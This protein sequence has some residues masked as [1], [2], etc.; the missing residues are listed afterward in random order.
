M[1][2]EETKRT[3]G[4]A[5]QSKRN[6]HLQRDPDLG[7]EHFVLGQLPW[8]RLFW[9]SLAVLAGAGLVWALTQRVEASSVHLF[10]LL[11]VSALVLLIAN[12]T[13]TR[14]IKFASDAQ[15]LYF[16]SRP[17]SWARAPAKS[18]TWLF[19]PWSNV[20]AIGVQLMLDES[21]SRK[22]VTFRIRVSHDEQRDYLSRVLM[23]NLDRHESDTDDGTILVGFS[24]GL[25]SPHRIVVLMGQ[26]QRGEKK[27]A[28][29]PD[30][31]L[32]ARAEGLPD[33]NNLPLVSGL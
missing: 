5:D 7:V 29:P 3:T 27:K 2:S 28:V 15:G 10:G 25:T 24:T 19:V 18:Q 9:Q 33:M 17:K 30:D 16:P 23:P 13:P 21:G 31:G 32:Q 22:G 26:F 1:K 12:R 20:S 4:A 14:L 6:S 11:F 8:S